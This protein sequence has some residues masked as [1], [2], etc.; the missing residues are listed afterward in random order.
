MLNNRF[1]SFLILSSMVVSLSCKGNEEIDHILF[2]NNTGEDIKVTFLINK[3]SKQKDKEEILLTSGNSHKISLRVQT[4][5]G[6]KDTIHGISIGSQKLSHSIEPQSA[7]EKQTGL[8]G[9]MQFHKYTFE[10]L[11]INEKKNVFS[12]LVSLFRKCSN[13]EANYGITRTKVTIR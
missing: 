13:P 11:P 1:F 8:K 3:F 7:A 9:K 5:N 12:K 6:K 2:E 4:E 10:K